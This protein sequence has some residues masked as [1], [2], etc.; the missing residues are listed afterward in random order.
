MTARE[1][2]E[3]EG[4]SEAHWGLRRAPLDHSQNDGGEKAERHDRHDGGDGGCEFH[5]KLLSDWR[6]VL[7]SFFSVRTPSL[8]AKTF[9]FALHNSFGVAARANK[10]ARAGSVHST[11][12]IFDG[13][14]KTCKQ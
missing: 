11:R 14:R 2:R 13:L 3:T 1:L 4:L 6:A 8:I 5:R 10:R 9:P 7:S 12:G